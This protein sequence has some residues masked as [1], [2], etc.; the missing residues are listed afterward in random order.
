MDR[1]HKG[2]RNGH[3][4]PLA[5]QVRP[6]VR[7]VAAPRHADKIPDWALPPDLGHGV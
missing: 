2:T 1:K 7:L 4:K 6:V 3:W 5:A